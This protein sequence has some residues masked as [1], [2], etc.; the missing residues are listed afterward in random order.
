MQVIKKALVLFSHKWYYKNGSLA[1]LVDTHLCFS[2]SL[3]YMTFSVYVYIYDG[4]NQSNSLSNSAYAK[5]I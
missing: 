4:T 1:I 5:S 3:T 2:A